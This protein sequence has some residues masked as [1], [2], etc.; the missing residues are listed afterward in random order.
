M[1]TTRLL[2]TAAI[3]AATVGCASGTDPQPHAAQPPGSNSPTAGAINPS[4]GATS[5]PTPVSASPTARPR[6]PSDKPSPRPNGGG[7]TPGPTDGDR[8]GD[9]VR[10]ARTL[11]GTVHRDAG[12]VLLDVAGK[13]WALLGKAP[14]SLVTGHTATATGTVTRAPA[15]CP[16]E[17]ALNVTR[18]S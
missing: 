14:Q 7:V 2:A 11:T 6:T 8:R 9:L 1:R 17:L 16:A 18:L 15:G 5:G 12:W 4:P 13:R 10:G 3:A